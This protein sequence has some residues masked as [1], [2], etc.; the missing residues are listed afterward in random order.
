MLNNPSYVIEALI[1]VALDTPTNFTADAGQGEVTLKWTDPVDK[2]ATPEGETAQDPQQL[3]AKWS[4]TL[5]VRNT[6]HQP[7]SPD[8][9]TVILTSSVR[10]QYQT[11]GYVDNT[12]VNGTP[13]YYG[14]FA[15]STAGVPSAGAFASAT[16]IAGTPLSQLA[17][18]TLIKIL[19]NGS[20]VEFYV[21]KQDYE[22]GMNGAGRVLC[23]RKKLWN[24]I[25]FDTD[26]KTAFLPDSTLA[27]RLNEQYKS[28]LSSKVQEMIGTTTFRCFRGRDSALERVSLSIFIP[29]L[30][31]LGFNDGP[32]DGS[33]L[34]IYQ[35]LQSVVKPVVSNQI[36]VCTRSPYSPA[37]YLSFDMWM[38][39]QNID[40]RFVRSG[41]VPVNDSGMDQYITFTLPSTALVDQDLNLIET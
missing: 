41:N 32:S 37:S 6:D 39:T 30:R 29:S 28:R 36:Y 35:T 3:V 34:P 31:E 9:G 12:V 10:N 11:N 4:H 2:Y 1:V 19:E 14:V 21:A 18:G 24:N 26:D 7:E 5:V 38:I 40:Q 15:I 17:E 8:D 20:P 16:P 13:Y 25:P 23:V 22:S 27:V 33:R